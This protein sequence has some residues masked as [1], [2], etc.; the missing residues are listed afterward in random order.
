MS[1]RLG[2][3]WQV[4]LHQA[5]DARIHNTSSPRVDSGDGVLLNAVH[6]GAAR[7]HRSR[8]LTLAAFLATADGD[9][10]LDPGLT[11][12]AAAA[13]PQ[14]G[15]LAGWMRCRMFSRHLVIQASL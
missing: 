10:Q 1:S 14:A 7:E 12:D 5:V 8:K 13:G 15:W 3:I 9:Q 6:E 11:L 2:S 4:Q